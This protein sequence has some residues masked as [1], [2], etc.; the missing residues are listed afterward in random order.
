[1]CWKLEITFSRLGYESPYLRMSRASLEE[2]GKRVVELIKLAS[3]SPKGSLEWQE[4]R[5][6]IHE[7]LEKTPELVEYVGSSD[8][9]SPLLVA[10]EVSILI[11]TP[12]I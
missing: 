1:M 7:A 12:H 6:S 11:P 3:L 10:C 2:E 8:E 5:V 9:E 4:L